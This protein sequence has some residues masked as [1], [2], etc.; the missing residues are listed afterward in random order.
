M[1]YR[2][3]MLKSAQEELRHLYGD[4][5]VPNFGVEVAQKQYRLIKNSVEMLKNHPRMGRPIPELLETGFD[6]FRQLVIEGLNKIVYQIDDDKKIVYIHVFCSVRQDFET[7]LR[8]RLLR[9]TV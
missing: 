9:G 1:T 8:N 5:L 2:V 6:H 7:I 4:Y 3:V